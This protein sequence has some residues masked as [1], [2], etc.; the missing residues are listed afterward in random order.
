MNTSSDHMTT[1]TGLKMLTKFRQKTVNGN[2]NS[3]D[4]L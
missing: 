2:G 4:E 3:L 1:R